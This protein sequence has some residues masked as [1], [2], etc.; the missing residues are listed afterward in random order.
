MSQV[1]E[2]CYLAFLN[3]M[4]LEMMTDKIRFG[5]DNKR[6]DMMTD[7]IQY[8]QDNKDAPIVLQRP[9]P[10][11]PMGGVQGLTKATI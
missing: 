3:R 6:I 5:Q 11:E 1:H 8:G 9:P 7:K 10:S 2:I 4:R